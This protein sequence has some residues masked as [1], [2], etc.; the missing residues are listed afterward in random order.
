MT[1]KADRLQ[2]PSNLVERESYAEHLFDSRRPEQHVGLP[3]GRGVDVDST[4]C[5]AP[6]GGSEDESGD[7]LERPR[8]TVGIDPALVTV[9]CV[10]RQTQALRSR[11]NP[12]G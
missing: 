11:T 2:R 9:R 6:S 10:G 8:E 1:P 12:A 5:N 4:P 7:S 3:D